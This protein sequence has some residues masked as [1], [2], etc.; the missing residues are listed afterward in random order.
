MVGWHLLLLLVVEVVAYGAAGRYLHVDHGWSLAAATAFSVGVY[1]GVRAL[2]VGNEFLL[3]RWQGDPIP[4]TLRVAP[5]RLA[6]MYLRELGG[7][8][9]MFSLVL[10]FIPARRSVL[11]RPAG[12]P[13]SRLPILLLHGLACNRGNWFWFR[14]QLESRGY[15]VF[16]VDVTPPFSHIAN[17]APQVARAVDEILAATGSDRLVLIG[18]SM[19][20]LVARAYL[21][22]SGRDKVAHVI[23]LGSP[24]HGTWMTRFA[25]GPNLRDMDRDSGW[26]SALREREA[27]RS[28]QPYANFTCVYTLHDNLVAPQ[29]SAVLPGA[30]QIVL[31]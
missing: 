5:S 9:L 8:L 18:H 1:L 3:A 23:T 15:A 6:L 11:D 7:W 31:S 21:D 20:G 13:L 19:G 16:T 4:P 12:K 30:E 24:H 14:H 27:R 25:L 2:L 28:P 17:F 22:Q 10:P 29:T 26:L